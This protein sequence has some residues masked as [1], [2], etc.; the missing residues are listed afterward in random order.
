M[1]EKKENKELGL[2][3][4]QEAM[5]RSNV[6]KIADEMLAGLSDD[7]EDSEEFDFEEDVGDA[8]ERP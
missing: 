3:E 5:E 2:V 7:S 8:K 6:E 4:F 1:T